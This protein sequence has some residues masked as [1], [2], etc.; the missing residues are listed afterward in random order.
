MKA[1]EEGAGDLFGASLEGAAAYHKGR[2][3]NCNGQ[4]P[5]LHASIIPITMQES[6]IRYQEQS[7][8]TLEEVSP[9]NPHYCRCLSC[10]YVERA[11][12]LTPEQHR[13]TDIPEISACLEE[14][15]R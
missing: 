9:E 5:P 13:Q 4:L 10:F 8:E 11:R 1:V 6:K 14:C 12:D 3:S 15:L 2:H 7:V